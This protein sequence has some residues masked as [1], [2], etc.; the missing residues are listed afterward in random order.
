MNVAEFLLP[1]P[2]IVPVL[3]PG[4]RPAA[5]AARALDKTARS[6]G[7]G[8][9]VGVAV[10]QADGSTFCFR[11]TFLAADHPAA[12]AN[13]F[14]LERLVKFLLWSRGGWRVHVEGSRELAE[15]LRKHYAETGTGQFDTMMMGDRIYGRQFEVVAVD[16]LPEERATTQALG[17]HRDGCRIGFDLGGSDRKVSAVVDGEP[18]FTEETVW[19]PIH[20]ADPRYHFDGIMDSLRKAAAHLPRV[21]AIGGSAA[22]VYVNNQP[23]VASLYRAVP[24]DL[25]ESRIKPIFADLKAAWGGVPFEVA[26]DG[27]VTALAGSMALGRNA[28]LGIAMG[29]STA[30]GYVTRDGNITSWLNELAFVPVD[31]RPNGPID[32]WSTDRGVGSQYY[33]QQAVGRLLPASGIEFDPQLGLPEK[34]KLVQK[35]MAEGDDRARRIYQTLGTYFGYGLA[36]FAGF[37]DCDHVLVLGRVM[38]GEGGSV[39]LEGA[40]AVLE[41]EFPELAKRIEFHTPDETAKR[42]GQ[43][44]AAASLPRLAVKPSA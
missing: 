19:D 9:D 43:A 25:F 26:N 11:R 17:R 35:R 10:E 21:D 40:R 4:F 34:L 27:E 12:S 36:H 1:E 24:P 8:L 31:Y 13:A 39:I 15:A 2:K 20:Q 14:F 23:R 33:S 3:D 5:L 42:H 18:V 7:R 29:T 44:V 41:L 37:Y 6:S 28:V 38:T 22:G 16:R 30:A 32:E